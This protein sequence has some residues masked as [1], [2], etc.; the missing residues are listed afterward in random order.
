MKIEIDLKVILLMLIFFFTSQIE[1]YGIFI[2]FIFLHELIHIFVGLLL[3]FKVSSISMNIFGFSAQLYA[4]KPRKSYIKVITYL[5]GPIFNLI[6]AIVFYFSNLESEFIQNVIY[7]N[8]ALCIFNLF[9]I[10]PLDGGKILKEV[11]KNFLGNKNASIIMNTITKVF[12]LIISAVY[13][14]AILKIK[15]FAILFL[16]IY[17]WYLYSIEEKKLATLKRVYEIIEKS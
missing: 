2:F 14:I 4:Y 11:L 15:N 17:M 16:L 9:P 8:L 3:G 6:C 13:S 12:L 10:M 5:A 1:I 7:T